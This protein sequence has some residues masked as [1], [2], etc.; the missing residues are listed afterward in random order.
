MN[1]ENK[2]AV[3]TV[4]EESTAEAAGTP[5]EGASGDGNVIPLPT[6]ENATEAPTSGVYVH[7]FSAP[8]KCGDKTYT[9][10]KFDFKRLKGTDMLAIEDEMQALQ[11]YALAPEISRSFQSKMAAKA[12]GI[13]SDVLENMP[14]NEFNRIT[15]A[16]RDFLIGT[17]Y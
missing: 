13:G 15:N 3:A 1:D 10:L 9:T 7:K 4:A 14:L 5:A 2:K 11:Q 6:T 12:G 8:Y 17:G 16:A